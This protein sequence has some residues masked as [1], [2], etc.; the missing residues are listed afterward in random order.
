[1]IIFI[2]AKTSTVTLEVEPTDL[3]KTLKKKIEENLAEQNK[4]KEQYIMLKK[5]LNSTESESG[6]MDIERGNMEEQMATI[7]KNI[8]KLHTD[9]KELIEDMMNYASQQTTIEKS[10]ANLIKQTKET[11]THIFKKEVEMQNTEN[12][13]ARV[14][15]DVLNTSSQN[16]LLK[17]KLKDLIAEL[18]E[19]ESLVDKFENEIRQRHDLIEKKQHHVDSLNRKYDKLKKG[20][21]DENIGPL[22]A[23]KNNWVKAN[24]EKSQEAE[25]MQREWIKRQ[26]ELVSLQHDLAS[27]AQ[28]SDDLGT[29]KVILEQKK[30][31]LNGNC[32]GQD[33]DIKR[34]EISLKN[35]RNEMNKLNDVYSSNT[36]KQTKLT[37]EN[38]NLENEFV[39]RLREL[40]G[41]SVSLETAI[42]DLKEEKANVLADIIEAEKQI[43]LWERKIQLE[44]E[45][46]ETLDPTIGQSEIVGMKK[47]IHR[48]ELRF[49]Q[50]KKNQEELIKDMERAVCKRETITLKYKPQ[51]DKKDSNDKS[52]QGKLTR[53]IA[54]LKQTLKHTTDNSM[55]LDATIEQRVK[56]LEQVQIEIEKANNDVSMQEEA[57][58]RSQI[59]ILAMKLEKQKNLFKTIKAQ[60]T[61]KRYD[62]MVTNKFKFSMKEDQLKKTLEEELARGSKLEEVINIIRQDN[63]QFDIIL[64]R[65]VEW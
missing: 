53:Q 55:Q 62:E 26:T 25:Q 3:I 45:M 36:D 33:K 24:N 47:E 61:A 27:V 40:E 58:Q 65:L 30:M 50:L 13:I 46:Q 52:S 23:T 7:E 20:G 11:Y 64:S 17:S 44:K 28:G 15:I 49:E 63:P 39:Q 22:E 54:N 41:D 9:T 14:R 4:L 6:R 43:L 37:N 38:F 42:N 5:S 12:E 51:A 48:M 31:R 10:S 57:L 32:L 59:E 18:K 2:K 35:L 29:K 8:M 1:M 34:M 60:N 16:E 21:R 19:K 56:E